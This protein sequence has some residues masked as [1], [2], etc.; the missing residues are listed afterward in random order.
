MDTSKPIRKSNSG[1][2]INLNL[3][4]ADRMAQSSSS[5]LLNQK[6]ILIPNLPK[7]KQKPI[8]RNQNNPKANSVMN[9]PSNANDVMMTASLGLFPVNGKIG[10]PSMSA[11]TEKLSAFS[12]VLKK[13]PTFVKSVE[14]EVITSDIEI[15]SPK[16]GTNKLKSIVKALEFIKPQENPLNILFKK[17]Q[18]GRISIENVQEQD[19]IKVNI[20]CRSI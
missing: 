15:S 18:T 19:L 20:V 1:L 4:N 7:F 3:V 14:R 8:R 5:P 11:T 9:S 12:K 16:K 17:L 10:V 13:K 6:P 2:K